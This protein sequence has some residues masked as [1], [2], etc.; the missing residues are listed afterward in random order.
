MI[1]TFNDTAPPY[2]GRD[3]GNV[4]LRYG[5][6]GVARTRS[7]PATARERQ[8]WAP[9]WSFGVAAIAWGNLSAEVQSEWE[10]TAAAAVIWPLQ[11]SPRYTDGKTFFENYFTVLLLLDAG[12]SVPLAPASGPEWQTLPSFFEF[13]EWISDVY[14]LKAKTDFEPGTQIMFS[15]LPPSK[16]VFNGEW[17]G[18]QIIGSN[19]F[20]SGL[21][22][23]DNF[24]GISAMFNIAFGAID[25]T[26]K[27]WGRLWEVY[28]DTGFARVLLGPCTA[29]PVPDEPLTEAPIGIY[30]DYDQV[31]VESYI[32]FTT[33]T[34][35][36]ALF[37]WT[38]TPAFGT[39][40]GTIEFYDGFDTSMVTGA[41]IH[42]AWFD[43]TY[44]Y[45]DYTGPF[46]WAPF[47]V[48]VTQNV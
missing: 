10:E 30:N 4:I 41:Q 25:P 29:D 7:R 6:R 39:E 27:I 13:A 42:S 45:I 24:D 37:E 14:T 17:Y 19:T 9:P 43:G 15:G 5:T 47:N 33:D 23:D 16:S 38:G 46:S 48:T 28:P 2:N 44:G 32:M 3:G 31:M 35:D 36:A 20:T 21:E 18:E 12:A 26:Q 22:P 1:L 11:G 40:T 34:E 8:R